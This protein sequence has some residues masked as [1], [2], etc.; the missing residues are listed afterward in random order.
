MC[1]YIYQFIYVYIYIYI[2]IYIYH[3]P[4]TAPSLLSG[5]C[6]PSSVSAIQSS[7]LFQSWSQREKRSSGGPAL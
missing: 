6:T 3:V 5:S 4:T 2:H 1:I 7:D